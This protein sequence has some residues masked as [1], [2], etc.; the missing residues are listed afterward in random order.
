MPKNHFLTNVKTVGGLLPSE[1]LQRI[2]ALDR[3]LGGLEEDD[4]H[5]VGE[6]LGEAISRSWGRML[7]VWAGFRAARAGLPPGDAATGL[8]REKLLLPL[9]AELGY[10]RLPLARGLELGGKPYPISHL[11]NGVPIHL[12]GAGVDLDRRTPGLV[13]AARQSP[14]G[15]VQE[16]LN[17]SE[18]LWG[19]VSNGLKLRLLRDNAALTRQA[20][21]E[22]DLEAI[23]EAE[24]YPDFALLW[25]LAHESRV[26]SE[27]QPPSGCWLERWQQQG[28]EQGKRALERLREGVRAALLHLGE[29][30]LAHPA[31][32]A[33][34]EALREG[35]LT[36]QGYYR[37]LLR[38]VYRLLFL[39]VAEDREVLLDPEAPPEARRTYLEHYSTARLRQIAQRVR[40][41]RHPDLYHLH[42][43]VV[44]WLAEGGAPQLALKPLNSQLFDP[45]ATPHLS[46]AELANQSFLEA[47]RSL[48]FTQDDAVLRPVDYKNLGAEELGSVYEQLLELVPEVDVAAA[49]FAL[50]NRSGNE[51]K[52]TGS[53]YT[54]D[55]L[56]QVVLDE[57]LEPRLAEALKTPDPERALLSLRVVDP[58]VGSGHFL[59][60]AAHRMARALARIRS[61]ED[62]PSPEAQ[63][64]ALRDVI[65][66]CLYGVDVNEMSAE[67]C[68]VALWMEMA[69][70][71]KPLGFLDHHIKVGNSLLGAPPNFY[72][73]GI[74]SEAHKRADLPEA[75]RALSRTLGKKKLEAWRNQSHPP[76]FKEPLKV[77]P[78]DTPE[79]ALEQVRAK[80]QAYRAWRESETVRRYEFLADYWTAAWFARPADGQKAPDMD[81]LTALAEGQFSRLGVEE[82][83]RKSGLAG[84]VDEAKGKYRFFHWWL[85]FAEVFFDPETGELKPGGGFDVVLG[86]P[87]WERVKLQEKEFFA[88]RHEEIAQAEN[89][90]KRKRLIESLRESDPAL[91]AAF[92]E[93]LNAA[94]NVSNFLRTS[95]RYPLTGGGDVNT[96]QVFAELG[97]ALMG[98]QGRAGL[99]VPTGIATDDSNK[100]FFADL[101]AQGQLAALLDFE[102]REGIFPGVHRSYKF[103]VLAMRGRA[104]R[105]GEPARLSFFATNV[106]HL[107][108]PERVFSLTPEDFA[109]LNPNTRTCP[110]FRTRADAELTKK[111]YQRVPVLWREEPE[112]NPWGIKFLAMFHMSNDSS[113]FKGRGELE[114]EGFVLQGNR[115]VRG[116]ETYLPLYEA[117]LIWHFDHRFATYDG[118]DTRDMTPAEHASPEALP[119]PRYWVPAEEVEE[120]LVQRNREGNVV[121]QWTRGWLL[122]FR[123]IARSTDERTAIFSLMPRVGVGNTSPLLLSDEHAPLQLALLANMSAYVLDFNARQKIGG[124]HLT[125]NYLRQFP[126]LPPS[127]YQ[128]QDLHFI[129]PR[130]LELTYTA[131]DLAP[132]AQDVWEESGPE[133]RGL[134]RAQWEANGGH[135]DN[136]PGWVEGAYPFP[137]FR[138][139]E[140]RRARLRAE[141]DAYYARLY[142][143]SRE[144][145]CYILEPQSVKGLH[146]PSETFRVLRDKE[147]KTYGEYRTMRL[148]LEAWDRLEHRSEVVFP[149]PV[150]QPRH[151]R[152]EVALAYL[153]KRFSELGVGGRTRLQK[154]LYLMQTHAN[155]PLGLHFRRR[156][157]GPFEEVV[158]RLEQKAIQDGWLERRTSGNME[159]YQPRPGIEGLLEEVP[160]VLGDAVGKVEEVFTAFMGQNTDFIEAVTTLYAVWNDAL[161]EGRQP[162]DQEIIH[163]AKYDW[164]QGKELTGAPNLRGLLQWM[165]EVG[166]VPQGQGSSTKG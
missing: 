134:L 136:P 43:R 114:R 126:V 117:K 143:L 158:Y 28:A 109:L 64:S 119:L 66:H 90:A 51:R 122:G 110:V 25:L 34:K 127:A 101:V 55:A 164:H 93:A 19:F 135:P 21:V 81:G 26:Y 78:L 71:G 9:F 77:P 73:L 163:E 145:L 129:V 83:R 96:Y 79:D 60:A 53:Y 130:V 75:A 10:G 41:T 155:V 37:E 125:Y 94:E 144:E 166:L 35:R 3:G 85:E 36:P 106:A 45:T 89:A 138:W 47:I 48:A 57:A 69:E 124:T 4:Y 105:T 142:G 56:V 23:F 17:R 88:G 97:R 104:S 7:A 61:G 92:Q 87:P 149:K 12:V 120:R 50:Q 146:F 22:F 103:S 32:T 80:A 5:L 132:F 148:V 116:E 86:N 20:Y 52:T 49:H 82:Q 150:P 68:K 16:Y 154:M 102:N 112:E 1:L 147:M 15:L 152:R 159:I 38:L 157:Y 11:W 14:H 67:L 13:G 111:I 153:V 6:R 65:R 131:W 165:R 100:D 99:I 160:A 29:G 59:I 18:A 162:S 27:G 44:G 40:G 74:P 133:L 39:F 8:T 42:K 33:L 30:F 108:D 140:E 58:A 156:Q 70:P 62:E 76:L 113:L 98:Q 31:N 115:F 141:L 121:W 54:P 24:A 72:E 91:Y 95:G 84:P 107:G 63:R 46:Q 128:P 161:L 118:A 123:D 137:P 2:S 151:D 139:D